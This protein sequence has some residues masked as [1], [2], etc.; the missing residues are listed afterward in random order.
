MHTREMAAILFA[1]CGVR[2]C[3]IET[4]A[5]MEILATGV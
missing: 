1:A 2:T 4:R 5:P 3:G